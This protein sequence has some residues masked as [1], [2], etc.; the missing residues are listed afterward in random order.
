[1]RI[2]G[3]AFLILLGL[4]TLA[5]AVATLWLWPRLAGRG[6]R[7]VAGRIALLLGTQLG[8][9]ATVLFTI[10][11][12]GGFYTSWGQLFGTASSRY[13]LTNA[14]AP[15]GAAQDSSQ[16][17]LG[18]SQQGVL[19]GMRSGL[20]AHLAVFLPKSQ[21]RAGGPAG[22]QSLP[23]E[24]VDLTGGDPFAGGNQGAPDFQKLAD[25]HHVLVA[26]VT[27]A[28]PSAAPIPGVNVPAGAQGEL[29]WSQ[30]L[31]A[32]LAARFPVDQDAAD[33][34][35]AGAGRSG[36]AAIDLAVQD[37]GRYGLAAAAGDWTAESAQDSWPGIDKY[38]GAVPAPAVRLFYDS[39]AP[40]IPSRI[41]ADDGP[42][43]VATRSGL[44]LGAAL[45][46]LGASLDANGGPA[47]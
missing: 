46:W 23:V 41:R 5:L 12:L 24:V 47:A 35:I 29:F 16:L 43:V 45:D 42:L 4:I 13:Q 6:A 32:A 2:N 37:S 15:G 28:S 3:K 44:E 36:G 40:G 25:T 19:H 14:G 21:G 30:D 8:L 20:S 22:A 1:V 34:G 38:L 27:D 7:P 26:V 33:W 9:A 39:S 10:N 11:A 31:R 18:A 17:N